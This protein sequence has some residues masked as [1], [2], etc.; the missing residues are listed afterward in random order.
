MSEIE[1]TTET[2]STIGMDLA[3]VRRILRQIMGDPSAWNMY[4]DNQ[5]QQTEAIDQ[6]E[7][8]TP[9]RKR[10]KG[11]REQLVLRAIRRNDDD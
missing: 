1:T 9:K 3:A 6:K 2:T 10:R 4:P 8:R 7:K 5:T 11:T